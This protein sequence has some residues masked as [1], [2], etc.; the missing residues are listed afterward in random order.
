[1]LNTTSLVAYD[2]NPEKIKSNFRTKIITFALKRGSETFSH[3]AL[4]LVEFLTDLLMTIEE[5]LNLSM[6]RFGG[7]YPREIAKNHPYRWRK[8]LREGGS[9]A[10]LPERFS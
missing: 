8:T 7:F 5:T 9:R 2:N 10:P 6:N 1:M 3:H 4:D